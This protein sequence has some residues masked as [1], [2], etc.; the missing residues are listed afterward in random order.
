MEAIARRVADP[1]LG[2]G[3]RPEGPHKPRAA[4]AASPAGLG[5][6]DRSARRAAAVRDS[7]PPF[8][9]STTKHCN[10]VRALS[11]TNGRRRGRRYFGP[12]AARAPGRAWQGRSL[13]EVGTG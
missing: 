4:S 12:E 2:P 3:A 9:G 8:E 5:R 1:N 11:G 6:S 10:G 13:I 7:P